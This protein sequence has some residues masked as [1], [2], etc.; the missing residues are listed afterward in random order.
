[1]NGHKLQSIRVQRVALVPHPSSDEPTLLYV[2]PEEEA[3][4]CTECGMALSEVIENAC[5][6]ESRL[7]PLQEGDNSQ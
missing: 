6:E 3:I 7:L 5:P 2:G 4:G 1:V